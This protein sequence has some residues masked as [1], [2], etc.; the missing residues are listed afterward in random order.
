MR[1]PFTVRLDGDL[2][3]AV[4]SRARDEGVGAAEVVAAALRHHLA[5]GTQRDVY[6]ST[7]EE[8]LVQR[9]DQRLGR[10]VEGLRSV[11]ARASFDQS[12]TLCL[13]QETLR[14]LF[15]QDKQSLRRIAE[16]ARKE[17]AL[18]LRREDVVPPEAEATAIAELRQQ[19]EQSRHEAEHLR[20]QLAGAHQEVAGLRQ[21]LE[22]ARSDAN[23]W[24][25]MAAWE[26]RRYEWARQR[27]AQQRGKLGLGPSLDDCLKEYDRA[28]PGP[29]R[30]EPA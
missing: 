7:V 27:Q 2:V 17:A 13:V 26:A 4:R 22:R 6:L 18:R 15:E 5:N 19:L 16:A 11:V 21:E 25:T 8:Q 12:L 29:K 1:E 30:R 10:A 23:Y 14:V 20:R 9:L 3:A 24:E 28:V